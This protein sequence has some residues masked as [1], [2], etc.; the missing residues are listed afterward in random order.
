MKSG[1]A[2]REH[3]PLH[4]KS[5]QKLKQGFHFIRHRNMREFMSHG[6]KRVAS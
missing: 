5:L 1:E 3:K 2:P 4:H 6:E